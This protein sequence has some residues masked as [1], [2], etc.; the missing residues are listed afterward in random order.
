MSLD[1][2]PAAHLRRDG[3]VLAVISA[4]AYGTAGSLAHPLL[5]LGW[6]SAAVTLLRLGGAGLVLL[7]PAVLALRRWHPTGRAV[8]R[9]IGYGVTATGGAQLCYFNA[10]RYLPVGTASLLEFTA[11]IWLLGWFW[12][13]D[14]RPPS[15]A[16]LISAAL[17]VV[18]LVLVLDLGHSTFGSG[19]L[20]GLAWGLG[21]AF[22]LCAYF[23]L[24]DDHAEAAP[25]VL[26][27]GAGMIIGALM[28][29]VIGL[30]GILPM[31][32]ATGSVRLGAAHLAWPL[33]AA[34]VI[35]IPTVFAYLAGIL[36]V[37]RLSSGPASFVA[38]AEVI[39][40]ALFGALLLG[41]LP[42]LVQV[43]GMLLV[44]TGIVIAQRRSG[45]NPTADQRVDPSAET[46][47][48]H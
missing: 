30:L 14:R 43:V 48:A 41:Q 7:L 47:I 11:P 38:L 31:T 46:P 3:I 27:A 8:L 33:A 19:T 21:S 17:A 10:I 9:L 42:S 35:L 26:T 32:T 23:L 44:I 2:H 22:C 12:I 20:P 29:G 6:S 5:D 24:S 39:F 37:R 28:V 34:A 40:A 18:G 13:R 16:L 45:D 36:A 15:R 4:T 1:L 25:P